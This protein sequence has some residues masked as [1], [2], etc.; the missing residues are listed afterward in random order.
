MLFRSW[1]LPGLRRRYGHGGFTGPTVHAD[2]EL[3]TV[4]QGMYI[5]FWNF[6]SKSVSEKAWPHTVFG[7][8]TEMEQQNVKRTATELGSLAAAFAIIAALQELDDDEETFASNFLLYQALRYQAEIKQWTPLY[9]SSEALRIAKSPTATA[10]QI[11]QTLK[12]FTQIKR[13]GLY[14]LGFP[15]D[16]TDIFYQ[17]NTGRYKKGD[18]KIQKYVED[19]MPVVRGLNKS[20]N[21]K[22][23]AQYFLG[24]TYN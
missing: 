13:E 5:S 17:R 2:E 19:L 18:R 10:R 7:Q 21:A 9:G 15:V 8:L 1:L 22:D 6:L 12:L 4:T 14:N 16:E 24:G 3:G 20:G 11:E 23:A